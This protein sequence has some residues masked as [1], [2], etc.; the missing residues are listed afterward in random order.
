MARENASSAHIDNVDTGIKTAQAQSVL[1]GLPVSLT[2]SSFIAISMASLLWIDRSNRYVAW[3]LALVLTTNLIRF[4]VFFIFRMLRL[5]SLRPSMVLDVLT[6]S[7]LIGGIGWAIVPAALSNGTMSGPNGYLVFIITGISAGA[8]IQNTAYARVSI[9]FIGPPLVAL[10]V[11]T[12]SAGNLAGLIVGANGI[13]LLVM[14]IRSSILGEA[15]FKARERNTLEAKAMAKSLSSANRDISV[16]NQQLEIM[17]NRDALTGLHNRTGFN[18]VFGQKLK[19]LGAGEPGN[20]ALAVLDIDRFKTI[21]DTFGHAAGDNLL[22]HFANTLNALTK[23][24]DVVGRIGGDEFAVIITDPN[25]RQRAVDFSQGLIAAMSKPIATGHG[26]T[27]SGASVGVAFAPE[28]A[29]D[30]DTLFSCADMALYA[31]K[32]G[33]RRR[34][35]IFDQKLHDRLIR[36]RKIEAL[37]PAAIQSG[38]IQAFFQPQ[39]SLKTGKITG[40]E[41]LLRWQCPDLGN[42]PA[43]EI[44]IAAAN[45]QYLARSPISWRDGHVAL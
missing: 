28:H 6:L 16:A 9:A 41:A 27:M 5:A 4:V 23:P 20:V 33:G 12:L 11:L 35:H 26:S 30:A 38:E 40:F 25:I 1:G 34:L 3:W 14:M 10:N 15:Q 32:E 31:A 8:V 13:L 45:I 7:A 43:P 19:A 39:A 18:A 36:Q 22:I 24:G 17:A 37:L 2:S 44:I 21:N 42:I 29:T